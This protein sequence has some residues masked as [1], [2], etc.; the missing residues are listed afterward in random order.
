MES[1]D[2]DERYA[3]PELVWGVGP[4]QFVVEQLAGVTPGRALDLAT[5]EGRNA[6]WL[7]SQ[8]WKVT[9]VDFSAVGLDR[10]AQLARDRGVDIEWVRADLLEYQPPA[11]EF[12]LIV[13]AYL[14]LAEAMLGPVLRR[15]ASA[16]A[17]GGRLLFVGHDK[18]NLTRGT[19]GPQS[20]EVLHSADHVVHALDGLTI[21]SA[22][23]RTRL[24]AGSDGERTAIDT[25]VL[26]VRPA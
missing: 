26:A 20:S 1:Q 22:G 10:A 8:G 9:G 21:E 19:G 17:P 13:I 18:E 25:L 23:Q 12:D 3:G 11:G 15:A 24:V 4:N 2:W 7:A 6:I 14:Q 16:V 5:G